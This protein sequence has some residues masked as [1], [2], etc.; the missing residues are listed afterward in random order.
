MKKIK[1]LHIITRLDLGGSSTNTIETVARLD[2][3][4][5][6]AHL[7]FGRT[8]DPEGKIISSLKKRG[9]L[10]TQIDDLRREI[11]PWLDLKSFF[12]LLREI[13][14]GQ[15]DIVHTHT[16][17][18]G[19][20]GRWAAK[21]AGVKCIIHTPHGHIFYGYFNSFISKIFIAIEQF[22]AL[23]THK[24]ITLTERGKEEHI[25][26]KIARTEKFTAIYSGVDLENLER[27]PCDIGSFKK[28]FF[29]PP[30]ATVFG[31]VARIDPIK[32]IRY[33]VEAMAKLI[34]SFPNSRLLIVGDGT[35]RQEIQKK[36][37]SLHLAEKVIFT[38]YREDVPQL[39][40]I[41]DVFVLPSLNEGMGRVILEAMAFAKPVIATNTG[42]I[43]EIV[44]D[45]KTGILV[46]P[47][48]SEPLAEAMLKLSADPLLRKELGANGKIF[49]EDTF[50]LDRMVEK[51]DNLYTELMAQ[52]R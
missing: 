13:K 47:R 34:Q 12:L 41:M 5:Y 3:N 22:T 8:H 48:Q 23:I 14:A 20:V 24:I 4:K 28:E 43:P 7:S 32:G 52:R 44:Q 18:A 50:T 17:K 46:A 49:L 26:F 10:F 19:V 2:R 40:Q 38:G 30:Q 1:V 16:S 33:L 45:G 36:V 25:A 35:E 31:T 51:I 21:F 6:D 42:G 9:I 29:V 11:H 15:Y 37:N 27:E 39:L